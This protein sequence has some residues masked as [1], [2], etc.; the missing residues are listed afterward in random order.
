[1]QNNFNV[2]KEIFKDFV[3]GIFEQIALISNVAFL[4]GMFIIMKYNHNLPWQQNFLLL[5]AYFVIIQATQSFDRW[6]K[7]QRQVGTF[8]VNKKRFTKKLGEATVVKKSDMEEAI[9]Y[10]SEIEDYLGK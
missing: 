6:Y 4:I 8:P 5:A 2:T 7:K 10:L 3:N 1:M 9:L